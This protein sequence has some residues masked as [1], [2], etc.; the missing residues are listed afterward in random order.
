MHNP[1]R[2]R[3]IAIG[4]SLL[5]AGGG[6]RFSGSAGQARRALGILGAVEFF[7]IAAI[8]HDLGQIMTGKRSK[9]VIYFA[10]GLAVLLVLFALLL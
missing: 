1:R 2:G 6:L 5:G 4:P 7:G 9:W 8:C 10:I 3:N